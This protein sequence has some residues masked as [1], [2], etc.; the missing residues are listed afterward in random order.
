M[1]PLEVHWSKRT[2]LID[3]NINK[4][5]YQTFVSLQDILTSKANCLNGALVPNSLVC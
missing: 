4:G 3:Y 2:R 1:N 5:P